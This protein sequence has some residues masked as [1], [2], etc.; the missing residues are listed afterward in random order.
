MRFRTRFY[1]RKIAPLISKE[2][3]KIVEKIVEVPVDSANA[4]PEEGWDDK[5]ETQAIVKEYPGDEDVERRIAFTARM[6]APRAVANNEWFFQK[7]FG[8]GDFI[9]A[10]QIVIPP[11]GRKPRKSSK[12][13]T[14]I[15]LVIEGAVNLKVCET[16]LIIASGG[17]FMI[18]RGNTYSIENIAERDAKLFFTQA[19]KIREGEEDG[20]GAGAGEDAAANSDSNAV[21][22]IESSSQPPRALSVAVNGRAKEKDGIRGMSANV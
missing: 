12:D 4:N 17:M 7:I 21:R 19:R 13:N 10:G 18:P 22:G 3:V 11:K 15:F 9:A 14:F 20:A 2:R 5:M 16:S 8:D 1:E 6:F